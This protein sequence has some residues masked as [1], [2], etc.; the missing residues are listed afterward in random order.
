MQIFVK[1]AD[2]RHRWRHANP[3]QDAWPSTPA[4]WWHADFCQ[5]GGSSSTIVTAG[6]V[7]I[8]VKTSSS[9]GHRHQLRGGMQIF[10]RTAVPPRPSTSTLPRHGDMQIFIKVPS[11]RPSSWRYADLPQDDIFSWPM[12]PAPWWYAD[13][14]QDGGSS[15]STLPGCCDMQIIIK[16]PSPRPSSPLLAC[17]SSSRQHFLLAIDTTLVVA[18][19]FLSGRRFLLNH[20]H[21]LSIAAAIC[22]YS[23]KYCLLDH[24]HRWRH[25]DLRQDSV[26]S[27]PSTPAP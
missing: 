19:R 10:V 16:V 27:W 26:F 8:F 18:C 24:R 9:S 20:R 21:Q 14:R 15:T 7:Q 17:K 1:T 3:H 22:Q 4:P 2:H 6:G 23:S 12:T 11:P 5:E 13:F 25:A